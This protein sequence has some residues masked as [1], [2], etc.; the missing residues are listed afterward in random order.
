M[1]CGS[2]DSFQVCTTCG[3]SPKVRQIRETVDWDTPAVL[4]IDR[5]DQWVSPPGG[6][7]SSAA[8]T[9]CSTFSSLTVRGRPGRGSSVSP[10]S[11]DARNRD[12][13]FATVS[14]E[15]PSSAAT[16]WFDAPSAQARTIRDR[17]ASDCAVLR[18]RVHASSARRSSSVSSSE[19]SFG[20][21]TTQAYRQHKNF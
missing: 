17:S 16:A 11:R 15:I 9:T 7:C 19:A 8:V 21:G 6:G 5:V 18:L 2:V 12:R 10:S 4:A 3:L 20:L 13:H 1:N 14:R